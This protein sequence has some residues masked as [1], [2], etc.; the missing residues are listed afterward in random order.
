M[1]NVH[2]I[3]QQALSPFISTEEVIPLWE[4]YE[5][6][7]SGCACYL[8]KEDAEACEAFE[9]GIDRVVRSNVRVSAAEKKILEAGQPIFA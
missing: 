4:A 8:K 1:N 9:N 6:D 2:P 5:R 3:I 7:G